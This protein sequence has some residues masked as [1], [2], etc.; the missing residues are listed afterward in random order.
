LYGAFT[1]FWVLVDVTADMDDI[2]NTSD[3]GGG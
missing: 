2:T 3:G 1:D